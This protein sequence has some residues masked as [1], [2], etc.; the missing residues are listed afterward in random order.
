MNAGKQSS[1]AEPTKGITFTQ[2]GV[3]TKKKVDNNVV[4]D[5]RLTAEEAEYVGKRR[6]NETT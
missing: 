6:E 5:F 1:E 4:L 2:V 3:G